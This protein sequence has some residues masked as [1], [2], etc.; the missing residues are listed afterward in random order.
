MPGSWRSPHPRP[1]MRLMPGT[2][3]ACPGWGSRSCAPVL[4]TRGGQQRA[5]TGLGLEGCPT[6]T[7]IALT[8]ELKLC[9]L[10]IGHEAAALTSFSFTPSAALRDGDSE[11][12]LTEL[13]GGVPSSCSQGGAPGRWGVTSRHRSPPRGDSFGAHFLFSHAA[14]GGPMALSIEP[15]S[16]TPRRRW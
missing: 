11:M 8:T 5:C 15:K 3:T 14:S 6:P 13:G 9:G 2:G 7:A 1:L 10:T 4:P 16:K 12:S